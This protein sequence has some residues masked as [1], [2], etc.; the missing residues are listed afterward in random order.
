M[1]VIHSGILLQQH[2]TSYIVG[3]STN[4]HISGH[5]AHSN[6]AAAPTAEEGEM[7]KKSQSIC[8]AAASSE[9]LSPTDSLTRKV[10]T[11]LRGTNRERNIA[12]GG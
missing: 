5:K 6:A 1:I 12:A 8:L 2:L 4:S 3:F 7:V 11:L 9:Q 10:G